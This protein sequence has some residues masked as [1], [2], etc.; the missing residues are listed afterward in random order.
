MVE[1]DIAF[2]QARRLFERRYR[3]WA[4]AV[5]AGTE[6][7][8]PVLDLPL[9]PPTEAEALADPDAAAAWVRSWHSV[10]A[11]GVRWERRHWVS[12]GTQTVPVRLRIDDPSSLAR[13]AATLPRWRQALERATALLELAENGPEGGLSASAQDAVQRVL[14]AVVAL[15]AS[16]FAC[17]RS[18]LD[19]LR[20]HPKS[21]MYVRQLPIRGVDT[22]WLGTHRGL[23]NTLH[24]AFT[25]RTD[26]GLA[27]A[28]VGVRIRFLDPAQAPGVLTDVTAPIE[29]W[30]ELEVKPRA[31]LVVENLETLVSLPFIVGT[32]VVH[33]SGYAV[34]RLAQIGWVKGAEVLYWGDLDSH[35]F[36]ILHRL[37]RHISEVKSV[38]M[39]EMTLL[40]HRD[41]WV[42]ETTPFRGELPLLNTEEQSALAV[43][44]AE[45]DVRLEQERIEWATA[46]SAVRS[47]ISAGP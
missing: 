26:L 20:E 22:K 19:F 40:A 16:D 41:L 8:A 13:F 4:V 44:R 38:L 47:R 34:D 1:R 43:L 39:D 10:A 37:R 28:P 2:A 33:G 45:G 31:V 18:V 27:T 42:V 9:H 17:L 29:Q 6:P 32:V 23:V 7:T 30:D 25:G 12:V 15:D 5:A 11:Q 14:G 35:G 24:L 46:L 3:E 21:G 36:A